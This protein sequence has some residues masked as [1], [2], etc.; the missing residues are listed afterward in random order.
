MCHAI[1]KRP[2]TKP[3]EGTTLLKF[4]YGQLYNEKLAERYGRTPTNEC[5]FFH[6]HNSCTHIAGECPDYEALRISRHNAACQLLHAA[7]RTTSKGGGA[8]HK[9]LN[10]VLITADTGLQPQ[11]MDEALED[12]GSAP[13]EA[14]T[15]L[16]WLAPLPITE[17]TSHKSHTDV[18]QDPR[19]IPRGLSAADGDAECTT[20]PRRIPGWVLRIEET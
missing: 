8:L 20:F 13:T 10:L 19:S 14:H 4:I 15:P 16:D 5:P 12:E 17:D 2:A 11:T 18:S 9:A 6:K 1:H 7:I 3:K